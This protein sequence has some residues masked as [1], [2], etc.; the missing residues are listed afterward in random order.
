MKLYGWIRLFVFLMPVW[1]FAYTDTAIVAHPV[2]AHQST[3]VCPRS[4]ELTV[5]I[6]G[7]TGDLTS[8]KLYPA[9]YNLHQDGELHP[10]FQLIGIGKNTQIK[11]EFDNSVLNSLQ[12]FSRNQPT[13]ATWEEFKAHLVYHQMDFVE[14]PGYL[15]LKDILE[16]RNGNVI[17]YLATDSSYFRKIIGLLHRHGLLEQKSGCYSRVVIEKPFGKDFDSAT[18]L[19]TDVSLFLEENQMLRMDHY[20]GKVGFLKFVKFRCENPFEAFL[21]ANYVANIQMTISETIGIG[22]RANFYEQTGHLR[23]VIQNHAMQIAAVAAMEVNAHDLLAEKAKLL[24]SI[25]PLSLNDVIR[26]QYT[27]GV[28]NHQEALGYREEKDV[29]ADSQTETFVQMKYF[30]DNPRWQ[31]VPFYIRSGKRLPEQIT[32]VRYNFKNN[33]LHVEAICIVIQPK[34]QVVITQDKHTYSFPMPLDSALES[35]E[36]YENQLLAATRGDMTGFAT[37]DE[38]LSSWRLFTPI[39]NEWANDPNIPFYKAGSWAPDAAE[40]HIL[41]DGFKWEI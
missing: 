25:R 8:R 12:Q 16:K 20:L 27:A 31:G 41:K 15:S 5:V 30:I 24:Y 33:P 1:A 32:Q 26:G 35:R 37:L 18:E 10:R 19:Q 39:L 3:Q 21:N 14:E 7:A 29:S 2:I 28:V 6:F 34:P 17:Y 4:E 38:I 40:E 13:V 23:D 36:G 11:S 22:T 9:L